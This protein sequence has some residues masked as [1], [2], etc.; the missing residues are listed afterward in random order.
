MCVWVGVCSVM[1]DSVSPWTVACQ[2]PLSS[3]FSWQEYW[4]GLPFPSPGDLPNAGIKLASPA[5]AGGFFA[6]ESPG[7]PPESCYITF[8]PPAVF[9]NWFFY[10]QLCF[11]RSKY[12]FFCTSSSSEHDNLSIQILALGTELLCPAVSMLYGGHTGHGLIL[13]G[14]KQ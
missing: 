8:N 9:L 3:G 6:P 13:Q 11:Y 2:A 12:V 10:I 5:L 7:K 4:N 1:S 14:V